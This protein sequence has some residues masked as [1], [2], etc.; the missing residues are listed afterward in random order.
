MNRNPII[1]ADNG[2]TRC[3]FERA[4]R[5]QGLISIV[6][7]TSV[8]APVES[9]R[10]SRFVD[11]AILVSL[12]GIGTKVLATLLGEDSDAVRRRDYKRIQTHFPVSPVAAITRR[13][14]KTVMVTRH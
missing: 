13:R 4:V 1:C 7:S 2:T 3:A 12:P 9:D 5:A 11:A 8:P 6:P 10:S 14:G